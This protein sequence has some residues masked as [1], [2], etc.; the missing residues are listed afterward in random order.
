MGG[1][2]RRPAVLRRSRFAC[3]AGGGETGC[4]DEIRRLHTRSGFER[5]RTTRHDIRTQ[6]KSKLYVAGL[7]APVLPT[8]SRWK[9]RSPNHVNYTWWAELFGSPK[10]SAHPE[11]AHPGVTAG[12]QTLPDAP[13]LAKVTGQAADLLSR[14][15]DYACLETMKRDSRRTPS[16]RQRDVV[17]LE[18]ILRREARS[19]RPNAC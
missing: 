8:S 11:S 1:R 7:A 13:D 9:R 12:A 19:L 18:V 14:V 17:H 10:E 16:G 15:P 4:P 3:A 5:H 2:L 6:L